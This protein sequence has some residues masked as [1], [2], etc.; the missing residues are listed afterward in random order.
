MFRR[1]VNK[2]NE[3]YHH[4]IGDGDGDSKVFSAL[5]AAKPYGEEFIVKK[6]VCWPCS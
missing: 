3:K 4:Y 2:H 5:E 1:S 6:E